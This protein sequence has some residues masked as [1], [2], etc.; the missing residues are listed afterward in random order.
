MKS[1]NKK[2]M[3]AKLKNYKKYKERNKEHELDLN[4]QT[5]REGPS[6]L[7]LAAS[8]DLATATESATEN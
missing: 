7:P 8:Q 3:K 2:L 6:K 5:C 4:N 1:I